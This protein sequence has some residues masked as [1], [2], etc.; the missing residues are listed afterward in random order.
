MGLFSLT[1]Y[2]IPNPLTSLIGNPLEQ[3]THPPPCHYFIAHPP[4]PSLRVL[5]LILITSSWSTFPSMA[6][7]SST[8]HLS[9]IVVTSL[10]SP[11]LRLLL[12]PL[13]FHCV[14]PLVIA[15]PSLTKL[16]PSPSSSSI[17]SFMPLRDP[18]IILVIVLV[19]EFLL[20][21]LT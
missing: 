21:Y 9:I 20:F 18:V 8:S 17:L 12:L 7:H 2:K 10:P 4:R 5:P 15:C 3:L 14:H 19:I 11:A 16:H 1:K 6:T 13:S